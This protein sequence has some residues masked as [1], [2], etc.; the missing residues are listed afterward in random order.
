MFALQLQASSPD[1]ELPPWQKD[2]L[3]LYGTVFQNTEYVRKKVD[4]LKTWAEKS[5]DK[6]RFSHYTEVLGLIYFFQN[7]SSK[8]EEGFQK[9]E[10]YFVSKND[11]LSLGDYNYRKGFIALN[12]LKFNEAEKHF[13]NSFYYFEKQGGVQLQVNVLYKMAELYV[14]WNKQSQAVSALTKGLT[15][16]ENSGNKKQMW[17]GNL[18]LGRS[19]LNFGE[20]GKGMDYYLKAMEISKELKDSALSATTSYHLADYLETRRD[21]KRA[22]EY[23]RI[24]YHYYSEHPAPLLNILFYLMG[25]L[26]YNNNQLDSAFVFATKFLRV[27]K[28]QQNK[29]AILDAHILLGKIYS[30][31]QDYLHSKKEYENCLPLIKELGTTISAAHA[32]K[33]LAEVEYKLKDPNAAYEY[34]SNYVSLRDS[35]YRADSQAQMAQA[36]AQFQNEKKQHE[37]ENLNK[38]KVLQDEE[39]KKQNMRNLAFGSAFG[40]TLVFSIIV[41][42]GYRRVQKAN[43]IIKE[44]RDEMEIQKVVV[45]RKNKE[46]VDSINYARRIQR[47]LLPTDHYIGKNID[48]LSGEKK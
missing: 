42:L 25:N 8:A 6:E 39:I 46:I 43:S 23:G 19:L 24:S 41:W 13:L 33:S 47:S 7:D 40:L 35:I 30:A 32:Y 38:D 22:L 31:K 48:R 36:E 14:F 18:F 1:K 20:H 11:Y 10:P 45:E 17:E 26:H 15:L 28:E 9:A 3:S 5:G 21:Y 44:Q 2:L 27:S 4:S 37:I 12:K 16:A 29:T 34:L